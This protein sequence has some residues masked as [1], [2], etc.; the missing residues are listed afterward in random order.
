MGPQ[1]VVDTANEEY[2]EV[3]N[4][5]GSVFPFH[6]TAER[7]PV[8]TAQMQAAEVRR[9]PENTVEATGKGGRE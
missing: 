3:A 4:P 5:S 9:I 8:G 1:E 7:V 6:V 2:N